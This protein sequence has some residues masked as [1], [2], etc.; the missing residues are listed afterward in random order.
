MEDE[1]VTRAQR[2]RKVDL[3]EIKSII[4]STEPHSWLWQAAVRQL[5]RIERELDDAG[6]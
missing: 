5:E 4:L 3:A 6:L 2:R 1:T